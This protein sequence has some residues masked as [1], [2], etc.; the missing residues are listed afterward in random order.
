MK[1]NATLIYI[2]TFNEPDIFNDSVEANDNDEAC[3]VLFEKY[4]SDNRP[5]RKVRRSM[6]VGDLIK[7]DND[8]Y[9]VVNEGFICI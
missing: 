5:D 4:N 8:L 2:N 3:D 1:I 6:S 9:A 7:I